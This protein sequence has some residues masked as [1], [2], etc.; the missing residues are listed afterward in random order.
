MRRS[1]R[2]PVT[3]VA[4]VAVLLALLVSLPNDVTTITYVPRAAGLSSTV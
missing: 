4:T 1:G 2:A 3:L